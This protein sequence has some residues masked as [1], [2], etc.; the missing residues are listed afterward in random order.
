MAMAVLDGRAGEF[1]GGEFKEG[2]VVGG[3]FDGG[4]WIVMMGVEKR[5][6]WLVIV[7]VIFGLFEYDSF[8]GPFGGACWGRHDGYAGNE[9]GR[10][11]SLM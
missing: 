11:G 4:G 2:K 1:R 5:R 7:T 10:V 6:E 9:A 3:W 8:E